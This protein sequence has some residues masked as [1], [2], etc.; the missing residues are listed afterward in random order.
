[1]NV[2]GPSGAGSFEPVSGMLQ[3]TGIPVEVAPVV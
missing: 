1:V 3:L 2:L